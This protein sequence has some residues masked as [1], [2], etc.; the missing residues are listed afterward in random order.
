MN[1][2]LGPS[3]CAEDPEPLRASARSGERW[4]PIGPPANAAHFQQLTT[5]ADD[6]LTVCERLGISPTLS[7]SLAVLAYTQQPD[8]VVDDVDLACSDREF[9]RL[10]TALTRVGIDC[11]ITTW[12]VLQVRRH[13]MKVEFDSAEQWMAGLSDRYR[14]LDTGCFVI[15]IVEL[16]DLKELYRRGIR[17]LVGKSDEAK[18]RH[19]RSRYEMLVQT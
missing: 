15:R 6:V 8:I 17:D 1:I 16:A 13:G 18:L 19:L 10:C 14:L 5:F 7:G 4:R 12:H 9:P 3:W 2:R 11:Q